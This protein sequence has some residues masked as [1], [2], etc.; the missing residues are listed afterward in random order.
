MHFTTKPEQFD[1]PT[2]TDNS[3]ASVVLSV[4]LR[5]TVEF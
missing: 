5:I 1:P 4:M 2:F 3:I